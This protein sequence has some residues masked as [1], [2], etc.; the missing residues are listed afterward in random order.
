MGTAKSS[1]KSM[2]K[3]GEDR[4]AYD[5]VADA[6][7]QSTAHDFLEEVVPQRMTAAVALARMTE[8]H[9]AEKKD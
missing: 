1:A 9:S 2:L 5:H 4:L 3:R 7:A 8:K 6:V